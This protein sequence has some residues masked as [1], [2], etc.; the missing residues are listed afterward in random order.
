M[1]FFLAVTD[2]NWFR[3]LAHHEPEEVNFW[4]PSSTAN[5]KAISG[6]MICNRPYFS[7]L[8]SALFW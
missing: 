6:R 8:T 3:F 4:R 2:D 7:L 5:F 1:K